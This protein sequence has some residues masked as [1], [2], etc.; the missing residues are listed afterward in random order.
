MA[1]TKFTP[2]PWVHGPFSKSN[3]T[4]AECRMFRI[5]LSIDPETGCSGTRQDYSPDYMLVSG[6]C[7]REDATLMA[8]APDLYAAL[9]SLIDLIC[10]ISPEYAEAPVVDF[11]RAALAKA[12]GESQ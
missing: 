9:G 12:H 6:I 7:R 4:N 5:G 1:E 11:A 8:A 2:G 10:E 3:E